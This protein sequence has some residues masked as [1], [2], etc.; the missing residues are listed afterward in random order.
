MSGSGDGAATV[1]TGKAA[2]AQPASPCVSICALDEQD[3]CI[4][5]YRSAA[6]ITDWFMASAEEKHAILARARERRQADFPNN[7]F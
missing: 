1:D 3:I 7:L 4:G 5:C 6:E 2:P